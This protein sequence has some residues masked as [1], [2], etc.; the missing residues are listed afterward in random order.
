MIMIGMRR[1]GPPPWWSRCPSSGK[2][3]RVIK[4]GRIVHSVHRGQKP[5]NLVKAVERPR[6][7]RSRATHDSSCRYIR[8]GYYLQQRY[9]CCRCRLLQT[10]Y[11]CRGILRVC[12]PSLSL[13]YFL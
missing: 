2:R 10:Y 5:E 6:V 11:D 1:E 9:C 8:D 3:V 4:L 12:L 7:H 13:S